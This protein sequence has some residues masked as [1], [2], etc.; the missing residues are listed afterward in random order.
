MP[1]DEHGCFLMLPNGMWLL[2]TRY[3]VVIAV[4]ATWSPGTRPAAAAETCAPPRWQSARPGHSRGIDPAAQTGNEQQRYITAC[5]A[6]CSVILV[7]FQHP[8]V[9]SLSFSH[10]PSSPTFSPSYII[11]TFQHHHSLLF[12]PPH[13]LHDSLSL[14]RSLPCSPPP[15]FPCTTQCFSPLVH[16]TCSLMDAQP[17]IP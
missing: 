5:I 7:L 17:T 16:P 4:P 1:P 10:P 12:S 14:L 2:T 9:P 8:R 15:L 6:L 3:A 13:I 11:R